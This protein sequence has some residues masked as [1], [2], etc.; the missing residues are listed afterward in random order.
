MQRLFS[1][2]QVP[3]LACSQKRLDKAVSQ[4]LAQRETAN[5]NHALKTR[6]NFIELSV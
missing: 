6:G 4:S 2:E 5:V 3:K 1:C